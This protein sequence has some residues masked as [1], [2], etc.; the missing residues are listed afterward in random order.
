MAL[1]VISACFDFLYDIKSII[2]SQGLLFD[3]I[4]GKPPWKIQCLQLALAADIYLEL[5]ICEF[6]AESSPQVLWEHLLGL[7]EVEKNARPAALALTLSA[8][9]LTQSQNLQT[10]RYKKIWSPVLGTYGLR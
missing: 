6:S 4:L 9:L 5:G 1:W 2:Y 7:V 3:G 8:V 10:D